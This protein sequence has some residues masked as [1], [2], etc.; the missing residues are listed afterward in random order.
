LLVDPYGMLP[1]SIAFQCFQL[2]A[3]RRAQVI[4]A[5]CSIDHIK[6][7]QDNSFET[8]PLRGTVTISKQPF[9]GPVG[10]AADHAVCM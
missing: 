2:V 9:G 5:R 7:T 4:Q 10:E 1:T 3:G 6:L 8:S